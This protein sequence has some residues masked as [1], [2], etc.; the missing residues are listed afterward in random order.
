MFCT[1]DYKTSD[2]LIK[3]WLLAKYQMINDVCGA[4]GYLYASQTPLVQQEHNDP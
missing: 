2:L 4:F 1:V 3:A